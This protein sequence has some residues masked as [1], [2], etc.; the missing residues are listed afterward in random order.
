LRQRPLRVKAACDFGAVVLIMQQGSIYQSVTGLLISVQAHD[1]RIHGP[2]MVH[3][4]SGFEP[5]HYD[6]I[7]GIPEKPL[8]ADRFQ[9]SRA[10]A[11]SR[12]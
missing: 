7:F 8:R 9:L 1:I 2:M 11:G 4:W 5:T 6:F 3:L 12:A 10:C